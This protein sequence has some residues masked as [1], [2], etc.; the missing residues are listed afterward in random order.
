MVLSILH[1]T[2][3]MSRY[4]KPSKMT[5]TEQQKTVYKTYKQIKTKEQW[6]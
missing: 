4:N 3:I 1:I 5:M 6:K 2:R